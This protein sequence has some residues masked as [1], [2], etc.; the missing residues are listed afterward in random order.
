MPH[1]E[2]PLIAALLGPTAVGKSR[3]AVEMAPRLGA[4]I[5]SV[6]SMQ[7]YRGLNIGTAKPGE[8]FRRLV[9]HH[10]L[11]VV[12]PDENYSVAEFQGAAR[13]IISS[14]AARDRLPLLVGGTGLYFEAVVF[15][16]RFPPGSCDDDLRRRLED[17]AASD[18][19]AMRRRLEEIDPDFAARGDA[20][21]MRRVIRAIEVYERTGRTISS[22]QA[23]RNGR[24]ALYRYVGAVMDAPRPALYRAIDARVDAMMEAGFLAEVRGLAAEGMLSRTARQALGYKEVLDHLDRGLPLEETILN[25][26]MR[27]RRYAKRQL[28]WFRRISGLRWYT[29][30]EEE[31]G[32]EATVTAQAVLEY[33]QEE[34]EGK[35]RAR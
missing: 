11:D 26:K 4:E 7:V 16:F 13:D 32:G 24:P 21:N 27:T 10:M 9:P 33:L 20:A 5:V 6:D 18:P 8:D 31:L 12:D 22:F 35:Q 30:A 2:T 3:L 1:P 23:S 34:M 25:I 29:L 15:D 14:I 28:T 17:L 19:D